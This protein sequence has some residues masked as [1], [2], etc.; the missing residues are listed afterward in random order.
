MSQ[1]TAIKKPYQLRIIFIINALMMILPFIFY[2]VFTQKELSI[3][4]LDPMYMIYTGIAYILSFILLV[5][6]ILKRQI[7]TFRALFILN[8][9]IAIPAGAYIGIGVALISTALSFHPKVKAYF[10]Q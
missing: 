9:L 6:A 1:V 10:A 3:E 5:R 4:G 2:V 7:K 8:I